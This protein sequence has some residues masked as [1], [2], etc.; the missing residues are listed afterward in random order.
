MHKQL[1]WSVYKI[2]ELH[3]L[4]GQHFFPSM[5]LLPCAVV[6]ACIFFM[7]SGAYELPEGWQ[8]ASNNQ[9]M[10]GMAFAT[11]TTSTYL[12]RSATGYAI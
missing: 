11:E 7:E 8:G 9:R 2:V 6:L 1:C 10:H 5:D 4:A 12:I 3:F